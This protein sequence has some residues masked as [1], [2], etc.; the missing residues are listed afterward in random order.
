MRFTP[1]TDAVVQEMLESMGLQHIEELFADIPDE[2]KMDRPLNLPPEMSE[3]ELKALL[4]GLAAKN[5][6]AASSL[7]FRG[8]S[9]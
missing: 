8:R 2:V 5:L 1:N 7:L 3:M 9:L 6:P 4:A